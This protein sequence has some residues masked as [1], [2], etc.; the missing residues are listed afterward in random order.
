MAGLPGEWGEVEGEWYS[1][2]CVHS[3]RYPCTR[4]SSLYTVGQ[5][6]HMCVGACLCLIFVSDSDD[7]VWADRRSFSSAPATPQT[8]ATAPILP[9]VPVP[10]PAPIRVQVFGNFC[11]CLR[12]THSEEIQDI[13]FKFLT[14]PCPTP[15]SASA[16][17]M[18]FCRAA[19]ML[20]VAGEADRDGEG[21]GA[22]ATRDSH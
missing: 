7:F 16:T 11:C 8:P 9:P 12:G 21:G 22:K 1:S 15:G 10:D 17:P 18:H 14:L 3:C 6:L 2:R 4:A 19:E 5:V 20:S 13:Y